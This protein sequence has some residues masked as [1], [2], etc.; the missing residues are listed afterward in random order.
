MK[1]LF[2]LF[3]GVTGVGFCFALLL[4]LLSW[5]LQPQASDAPID[6][7]PD[8]LASIERD[9]DVS[10]DSQRIDTLPRLQVDVDSSEG[11]DAS[12]WPRGESPILAQLVESGDLPP[13][14][15]RTGPEP[16]VMRGVDGIGNYGG[17]WLR[18]ASSENDVGVIQNRMS[19]T[20]FFRWS[21]LGEPVVPHLA[22]SFEPSED[23]RTFTVRLRRGVRWSDGHPFT[24]NDVMYWWRDQELSEDLTD[25]IPPRWMYTGAD[26]GTIDMIDDYTLLFRFTKPYPHFKRIMATYSFY[27]TQDPEHYLRP[28]HPTLGDQDRIAEGMQAYQLPSP[29]ALYAYM[30]NFMNPDC[31]RLWP[32]IYRSYKAN[33]PQVFVRNPFYFAVDES[34]NQ[35]PYIDRLQFAVRSGQMMALSFVNGEVSMQTRHVRY[36]NYT[37]LFDRAESTGMRVLHWYSATRSPWVINPNLNRRI[38]PERPSTRWKAQ[39]LADKRFRQALSLAIDR[40]AIIRALYNDQ[41]EPAQ[42]EPG[43]ESPFSSPELR[44]AF[45]DHDTQGANALLDELGLTGRDADG[46]R[47]YPD[48]STMTFFIEYSQFTDIGPGHFVVDDWAAVGVRAILQERAR[49]LF[50]LHKNAADFDFNIWSGE[51]DFFAVIEP[52]YFIPHSIEAFYATQ[53]AQWYA[54]GGYYDDPRAKRVANA[55]PPP[56]DHPM[57]RAYDLY[58]Q[59]LLAPSR[60][61][62]IALMKKVFAIGAENI[63]TINIADAP[64]QLVVLDEDMRNVPKNALFGFVA[65]TP[66]NA[67]IETFFF[68]NPVMSQGAIDDVRNAIV[69]PIARPRLDGSSPDT[70][71]RAIPLGSLIRSV[72]LGIVAL[73]LLLIAIKHPYIGRR[74]LIMIPTLFVISIIV[75][76]I[77]QLPEGDYLTARLVQLQEAGNADAEQEIEDLRQLFHFDEPMWKQY[78]RWMGFFWFTSLDVADAGLLQGYMGRSMETAQPVNQIVGDRIIL[79]VCISAG[80]I[81]FTWAVAIPI[82]I[83]SAV[84]Q[85]SLADYAFTLVGFIGMSIPGFLLALV[86]MVLAD[87]SGLFSPEYAAQP[88]WTWGKLIDLLRH[89]WV[90]VLVMGVAGT[91]GMIRVMR[92]NLLDELSKPYVTTA[93]AKGVRP[94]KLLLKYPVRVA[95][96]P[97]ISGI[98]HVFPQ[99]VSGGAIVAMVLS[100]PT[101]GPL[102]LAALFSEDMYLAGSMLMVLSMLGVL[103]TLVSDLLLLWLDPRVRYDEVTT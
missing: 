8:L 73:A 28:Y 75:F 55:R 102:L 15:D 46:M 34:G 40:K 25:G 9:R 85:Y 19:Y 14:R 70:I 4:W 89:I 79:T 78:A 77:I 97:F 83:Y 86:L 36:E 84:R 71:D 101:V 49:Q 82:G 54:L 23:M 74:L 96:N 61:E 48:G 100:L 45:I 42:V 18:V 43:P 81:L 53:W 92:A 87:V 67:G 17:T 66:G 99:L 64:P 32:W 35:L 62:Q 21:P 27:M 76:T 33:P 5:S 39:L 10:F 41:V 30:R 60:S 20:G 103:G 58:E 50:Y 52:R 6:V 2:Y 31:P 24:A 13:V 11:S 69:N 38:D 68:E 22:K 65:M 3:A 44:Q 88:E 80:T 1:Y 57:Y 16:L 94:I 12:W 90:P 93:R 51:S 59:A 26:P 56:R 7:D 63:W 47:T 72:I 98:G 95:L 91:A 37:E 29:R